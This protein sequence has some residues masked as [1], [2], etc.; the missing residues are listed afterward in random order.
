M[1][2]FHAKSRSPRQPP[3]WPGLFVGCDIAKAEI[4][5]CVRAHTHNADQPLRAQTFSIKNTPHAIKSMLNRVE[6]MGS[7][8]LSVCEPTGGYEASFL[9]LAHQAGWPI[10]RADVRKA[11]AFAR[12]LNPA[13][14]DALDA[15]ALASYAME[16]DQS[17][18]LYTPPSP[19]QAELK[20]LATY[21]SEL[22]T[23]RTRFKNK[24]KRPGILAP[25]SY[26]HL[27]LP[28]TSRV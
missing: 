9:A 19:H 7:T 28:T 8:R 22:I 3:T 26:T 23:E 2:A 16:R 21:R 24:A 6:A 5:I 18:R 20:S 12:S 14:T 25:V 27:T 17:L 4:V 11:S 15:Y 13:K 10:H 1:E